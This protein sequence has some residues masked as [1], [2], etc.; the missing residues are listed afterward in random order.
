MSKLAK[1]LKDADLAGRLV[2]AGLNTP[3]K[4]RRATDKEIEK[5]VGKSGKVKVRA[6]FK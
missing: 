5:A 2:K 6:R 1:K 3:K 4:L